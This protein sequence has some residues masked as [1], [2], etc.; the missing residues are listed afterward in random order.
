MITIRDERDCATP[1]TLF[2]RFAPPLK[3]ILMQSGTKIAPAEEVVQDVIRAIRGK[4][5]NLTAALLRS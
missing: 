5:V 4:S 3:G 2:D 1:A